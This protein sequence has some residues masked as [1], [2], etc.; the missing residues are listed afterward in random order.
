MKKII[1]IAALSLV[2]AHIRATDT[3]FPEYSSFANEMDNARKKGFIPFVLQRGGHAVDAKFFL[4]RCA[5]NGRYSWLPIQPGSGRSST[6]LNLVNTLLRLGV[7]ATWPEAYNPE[8]SN[9]SFNQ[10]TQPDGSNMWSWRHY[11]ESYIKFD[12]NR[13]LL[14]GPRSVEQFT[15]GDPDVR[16]LQDGALIYFYNLAGASGVSQINAQYLNGLLEQYSQQFSDSGLSPDIYNR[17]DGCVFKE[18]TLDGA[19]VSPEVEPILKEYLADLRSNY[20]NFTRAVAEQERY[21]LSAARPKHKLSG[22]YAFT[23]KAKKAV[24][25][26]SYEEK[27]NLDRLL[28]QTL[29]LEE[30]VED[31]DLA[32]RIRACLLV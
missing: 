25:G 12:K 10:N 27:A 15:I 22:G 14:K 24:Q 19:I 31:Q 16:L 32:A 7:D 8:G 5:R 30:P 20:G 9:R 4:V 3:Y 21:I 23:Q 11:S 2:Y 6:I 17:F 29:K 26:M 28:K 18:F 1:L 13:V